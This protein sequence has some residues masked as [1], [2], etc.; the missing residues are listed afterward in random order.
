MAA[1]TDIRFKRM[2]GEY[3]TL[4]DAQ[5]ELFDKVD[6]LES[7]VLGLTEMVAENRGLIL[8]NKQRIDVIDGKL[9]AIIKHLEV[10][11]KP[12]AGFVKE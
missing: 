4:H 5:D 2:Q 11:Y 10:P 7:A 8:A 12:P 1:T 6:T 9:D 3:Q